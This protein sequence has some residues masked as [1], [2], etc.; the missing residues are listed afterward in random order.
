MTRVERY[1]RRS[2]IPMLMLAIAFLVAYV[3]P[4]L[5][6]NMDPGLRSGVTVLSWSVWAAFVMDFG[7]RIALAENKRG[8]LLT[9]WYD[10]ALV[11]LP[12]LRPLRLLR[13]LT[14][15]RVLNRTAQSTLIGRVT[16]YILGV[17]LTATFL[18]AVAVLDVEQ[19]APGALITT[20]G[21]A[22]WWA[23]TTV[24]TVGYGDLYPVTTQGRVIAVGLMLIGIAMVGA[25]T[26]SFAAWMVARVAQDNSSNDTA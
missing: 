10:V 21:D 6:Q 7:V 17:T 8:Y 15:V 24:T 3:W 9:H 5:D 25:V 26:A 1:E 19:D 22:M 12:V 13:L 23:S 11:L 20:F 4:V 2:E 18:G 16:T 14:L